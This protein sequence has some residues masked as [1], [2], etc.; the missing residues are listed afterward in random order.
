[1]RAQWGYRRSRLGAAARQL[2]PMMMTALLVTSVDGHPSAAG[3]AQ[4]TMAVS[5]AVIGAAEIDAQAQPVIAASRTVAGL[6]TAVAV[7]C[8]AASPLRVTFG[9]DQGRGQQATTLCPVPNRPAQPLESCSSGPLP[10]GSDLTI[11]IEY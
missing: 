9:S 11:S 6:C 2:G 7:R 3:E 10:A 8:T 4:A 1:M 5:A